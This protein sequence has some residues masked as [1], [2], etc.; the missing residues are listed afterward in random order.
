M[1]ISEVKLIQRDVE[2]YVNLFFWAFQIQIHLFDAMMFV[3]DLYFLISK[4]GI[5]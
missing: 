3:S 4:L 5:P 2:K 1:K